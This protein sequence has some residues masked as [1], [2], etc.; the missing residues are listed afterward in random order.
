MSL[1]TGAKLG[2]YEVVG[3]LS[4]GGMD[5]EGRM[6]R[7]R[8]LGNGIAA[9]AAAWIDPEVGSSELPGTR[10]NR[11]SFRVRRFVGAFGLD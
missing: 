9:S 11:K 2:P 6:N 10:A 8:F 4:A 5:T 3:P 1:S 7:R